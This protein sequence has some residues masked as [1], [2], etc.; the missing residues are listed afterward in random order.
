MSNAVTFSI[1]L[2]NFLKPIFT[3]L[4]PWIWVNAWRY[5]D[6]KHVSSSKKNKRRI[7]HWKTGFIKNKKY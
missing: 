6:K 1:K 4:G 2:S 5:I 7:L 3:A